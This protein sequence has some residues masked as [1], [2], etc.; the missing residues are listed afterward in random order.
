MTSRQLT[1]VLPADLDRVT[2]RSFDGGIVHRDLKPANVKLSPSGPVKLLDFGLATERPFG[3]ER[4]A[5]QDAGR[6]TTRA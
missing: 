4:D 5:T 2:L 1:I 3:V 6:H